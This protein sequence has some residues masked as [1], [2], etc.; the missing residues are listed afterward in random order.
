MPRKKAKT[1]DDFRKIKGGAYF[2]P[3]RSMLDDTD[4][5]QMELDFLG[6]NLGLT[7]PAHLPPSVLPVEDIRKKPTLRMEIANLMPWLNGPQQVFAGRL[8][9]VSRDFVACEKPDEWARSFMTNRK[10]IYNY[11]AAGE[12]RGVWRYGKHPVQ[13]VGYA[14][15]KKIGGIVEMDCIVFNIRAVIITYMAMEKGKET[16]CWEDAVDI[17][18]I[19]KDFS[20]YPRQG[21][22]ISKGREFSYPRQGTEISKGREF[23][24]P[25]QGTEISKRGNNDSLNQGI[26]KA[27]NGVP[28]GNRQVMGGGNL[29]K[30][31][32]P[33]PYPGDPATQNFQKFV[34]PT[35]QKCGAQISR[36]LK[37]TIC[38]KC[39]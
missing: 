3:A 22:E 10:N 34:G 29:K 11:I 37:Y 5:L 38:G 8:A 14:D 39:R 21:T 7:L 18:K 2:L 32:S 36:L 1:H 17:I 28:I 13:P 20:L 35:C 23:S 16:T 6:A 30:N 15:H 31:V 12:D 24:Y 26:S 4:V 19:I 33:P 27:E 25:R 9:R